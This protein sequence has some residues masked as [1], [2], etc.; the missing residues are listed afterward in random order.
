MRRAFTLIEI[1]V[2]VAILSLVIALVVPAVMGAREAAR[3]TQC[4]NNM[5]QVALAINAHL[6]Q[7]GCYPRHENRFSFFVFMLPFLEQSSLFN[8]INT[9]QIRIMTPPVVNSTAFSTNVA[10]FVCPSDGA[11][12]SGLGPIT[13]AGNLGVGFGS[14]GPP[15]NGPFGNT[16]LVPKIRDALIRDGLANT[17]ALSE[18]YR[19]TGPRTW[20]P[21]YRLGRYDISQVGFDKLVSDCS[22]ASSALTPDPTGLRGACW[23]YD[24][25]ENSTYDHNIVPNGNSCSDEAGQ[26]GAWTASS[27]H[28][29]GVN[30]AHLD[31]HV[32]F[33]KA[34]ISSEVWRSLGTM[35]GGEIVS[36]DR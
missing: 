11:T 32:G 26:L 24:G 10:T 6:D 8:S 14:M 27:G 28:S 31:G 34:T 35:N 18:F 21:V 36:D 7:K 17:V 2:V 3:R 29:N 19:T 30:A 13:Y 23:A 22:A 12:S 16:V 5:R 1:L 25:R 20:Y 9:N 15:T 4:T 33:I